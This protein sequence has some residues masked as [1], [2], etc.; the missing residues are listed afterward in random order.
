LCCGGS[1]SGRG[2]K[3]RKSDGAEE[4]QARQWEAAI[5]ARKYAVIV[6]E[7][8]SSQTGETARE[9]KAILGAAPG[10]TEEGEAD[11]EGPA[12]PGDAI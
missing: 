2:R 10:E 5:S 6:D 4:E 12:E 11:W 9:L 3:R 7:A 8:H 1:H